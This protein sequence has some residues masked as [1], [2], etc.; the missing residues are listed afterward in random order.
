MK[1]PERFRK[2]LAAVDR[3]TLRE[4]LMLLVGVLVVAG[5]LWEALLAA[6]LQARERTASEQVA[7]AKTRLDKLDEAMTL[8]AQGIGDGM[9]D[10]LE[11]MRMLEQQL[12]EARKT[13]SVF[14]SDLV[15]PTQMREVL[16]DLITRQKGL[17]LVRAG[18]LEVQPLIEPDASKAPNADEPMLYRQGLTLELRGSYLDCLEYLESV[19]RLPWRLYWGGLSVSTRDYPINDITIEIFTLSLDQEWI[20]V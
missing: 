9:P 4:R 17:T 5:G 20:G 11:R 19:E 16:E 13:V 3:L 18:N 2:L 6:P 15:D 8:A 7:M 10:H 1:A 14:T 12:A